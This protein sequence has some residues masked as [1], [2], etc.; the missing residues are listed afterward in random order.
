[1][2][3]ITQQETNKDKNEQ[4]RWCFSFLSTFVTHKCKIIRK[5]PFTAVVVT[6]HKPKVCKYQIDQFLFSSLKSFKESVTETLM[7]I[8]IAGSTQLNESWQNFPEMLGFFV[9]RLI[10]SATFWSTTVTAG[11]RNTCQLC[12]QTHTAYNNYFTVTGNRNRTKKCFVLN[13]PYHLSYFRY[14]V[15]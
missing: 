1:M 10:H 11:S 3:K 8:I 13:N 9:F 4:P 14:L 7:C 2:R 5:R 6:D 12:T 15:N